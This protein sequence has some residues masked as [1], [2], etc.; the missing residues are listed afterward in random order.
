M[1]DINAPATIPH[2]AEGQVQVMEHHGPS[3]GAYVRIAVGLA[4]ITALEVGWSYSHVTG[5]GFLIPLLIMMTI[6]FVVVASNF[7]HLKFDN[8]LLTRVFYAGLLL[9]IGVYIA[10]LSS[11]HFWAGN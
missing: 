7:M 5:V 6:K 8:K 3:D 2:D 4:F 1:S 9:A 10:A 11:L